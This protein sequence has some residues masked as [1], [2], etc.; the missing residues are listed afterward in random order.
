MDLF[1]L[2][3]SLST[4]QTRIRRVSDSAEKEEKKSTWKMSVNRI[5]FTFFSIEVNRENVLNENPFYKGYSLISNENI[6]EN[7]LLITRIF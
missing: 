3:S 2:G 7:A 5:Y 4:S 6:F 1:L